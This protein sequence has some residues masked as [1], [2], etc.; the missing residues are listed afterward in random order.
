MFRTHRLV[1]GL[2]DVAEFAGRGAHAT[3]CGARESDTLAGALWASI[4]PLCALRAQLI[5][6]STISQTATRIYS[7]VN[8]ASL[9]LLSHLT[10]ITMM[11]LL[12]A[13]LGFTPE[14]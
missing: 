11:A 13:Q 6:A 4:P 7:S 5:A 9:V 2:A 12:G 1:A 14:S 8:H 10:V 3:R